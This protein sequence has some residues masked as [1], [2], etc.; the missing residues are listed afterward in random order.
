MKNIWEEG[1]FEGEVMLKLK[2]YISQAHIARVNHHRWNSSRN[3]LG[4]IT[5][6]EAIVTSNNIK[7][8]ML[9]ILQLFHPFHCGSEAEQTF[10]LS[11][12]HN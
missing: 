3:W 1:S 5:D 7:V 2:A 4:K 6:N 10:P 8:I 9:W 12:A 11:G